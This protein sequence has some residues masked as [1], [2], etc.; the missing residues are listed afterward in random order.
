MQIQNKS[1]RLVDYDCSSD[2]DFS[3]DSNEDQTFKPNF[4]E[5]SDISDFSDY[6]VETNKKV[7]TRRKKNYPQ[8]WKVNVAKCRRAKCLP[9]STKKK[10]HPAKAPKHIDCSECKFKCTNYVSE[11]ERQE[12]CKS[13]WGFSDYN[14]QKDFIIKHVETHQPKRRRI[15]VNSVKSRNVSKTYFLENSTGRQRV[16]AKFFEKTLCISNGPIN[17]AIS[18]S[19]FGSF[20]GNDKRGRKVPGN[21]TSE[22][23]ISLVKSHIDSFPVMESHYVRKSTK[24]LYLDSNLSI[25]KMYDLYRNDF[26]P[27]RNITEIVSEK[28]YRRIFCN[29]YN[30][31]FFKPKK[32][33]CA[34]CAKYD[35][36]SN[37]DKK[38]LEEEY[39]MHLMR[40][41]QCNEAKENDKIR[42]KTDPSFITCTFDLQSV[43]QLPYSSVSLFYYSRK[44]CVYNLTIYVGSGEIAHC[45][46][47]N[48]LNGK[49]GSNEIGS[50]LLKFLE[51]LPLT[52]TDVSLFCDTCGGQNRN[53]QVAAVLMYAVQNLSHLNRVELKFLESGHSHMEC[54]SMHSAIES[55]K[56]NKSAYTMTDWIRIFQS[57]RSIKKHK[58]QSE[59]QVHLLKFSDFYNLQELASSTIKNRNRDEF[60][61]KVS[62]LKIKCL[63]FEKQLPA[64]FFY[65]YD[66]TSDY[67]KVN[68]AGRGSS[69]KSATLKSAYNNLLPISSAKKADLV[70]LCD[71]RLIPEEIIPW[72]KQLPV[73]NMGKHERLPEPSND[74]S[75]LED[76]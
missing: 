57:A 73:V 74:E 60:G 19:K 13:F 56:K 27:K 63:K 6:M 69:K 48:E 2:G 7:L 41:N 65:R 16:C 49:R 35:Q 11:V 30:Y 53:Q 12:I 17:T 29:D 34:T 4:Q 18:G 21:K 28:T 26:C 75:D 14:R 10:D 59:Y 44:I 64:T 66:H 20:T 1:F 25:W 3:E 62:W 32:D 70:K 71:S 24:K 40:K 5:D 31:S 55:A 50:I 51:T 68:V 54:D 22:T 39:T 9:Y 46:T 72:Y 45:Y 43:L 38:D 15:D 8:A 23:G 42:C 58:I 61:D 37:A 67:K 36:A 47:W 52:V 33:L 76:E